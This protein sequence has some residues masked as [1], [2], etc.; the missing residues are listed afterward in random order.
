MVPEYLLDTC[1]VYLAN[2]AQGISLSFRRVLDFNNSQGSP[3][4]TYSH[5]Q[6]N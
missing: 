1:P 3:G 6:G 5:Y 2:K 4:R